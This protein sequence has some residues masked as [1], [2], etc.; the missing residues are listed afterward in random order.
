MNIYLKGEVMHEPFNPPNHFYSILPDHSFCNIPLPHQRGGLVVSL[1]GRHT[2]QR[3]EIRVR[4][5]GRGNAR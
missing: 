4:I 5:P 1:R 3:W 2:T